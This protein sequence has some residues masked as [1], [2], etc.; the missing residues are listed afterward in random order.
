[1]KGESLW[2]FLTKPAMLPLTK[3]FL[4]KEGTALAGL[5]NKRPV[6]VRDENFELMRFS[7]HSLDRWTLRDATRGLVATGGIGTGKSSGS[8]KKIASSFLKNGMGGLVLCV[9]TDEA[10]EWEELISKVGRSKDLIRITANSPYGFNFL[11]WEQKRS[12]DSG[13]GIVTNITN[14]FM[15]VISVVDRSQSTKSDD[16]FWDRTL[17]ELLSNTIIIASHL[18]DTLNIPTL[19]KVIQHAPQSVRII[20]GGE[21]SES[22]LSPLAAPHPFDVICDQARARCPHGKSREELERSIKFFNQGFAALADKTRSIVVISFTSMADPLLREPLLSLFCDT[23]VVSPED[24]FAGKVIVI[25]IPVHSFQLVGRVANLIWKTAFKRACQQRIRPEVPV[26]FWIDEC[27]YLV[28]PSDGAFQTTA[29][30]SLC[31]TV[32]LTQTISNLYAEFGSQAKVDALMSCLQ[33]KIFHQNG[34]YET[35]SWAS[36][37]IQKLPMTVRSESSPKDVFFSGSVRK[38]VTEST[39]WEDDVPGRVFLNLKSG[40]PENKFLV[41]GIVFFPGR[42]FSNGKPWMKAIFDQRKNYK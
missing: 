3:K 25:D 22:Y 31:C 18:S 38:T 5:S 42:K 32:F 33:T 39:Q 19:L 36:K 14:F 20:E 6:F 9:K 15:D 2:S 29:R 11:D 21:K 1:M 8:G 17:R 34:D 23:T 24:C 13:G 12:H 37:T 30:S 7:P 28:D 41:E 35:N 16:G 40:G 4:G 27:Q 26:F 10:L